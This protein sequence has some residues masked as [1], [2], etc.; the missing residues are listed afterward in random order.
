MGTYWSNDD[1]GICGLLEYL[2]NYPLCNIILSLSNTSF[3]SVLSL[4]PSRRGL[5][6]PGQFIWSFSLPL[7]EWL[8]LTVHV[9]GFHKLSIPWKIVFPGVFGLLGDSGTEQPIKVLQTLNRLLAA[10]RS[11]SSSLNLMGLQLVI[12]GSLG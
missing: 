12:R 4:K 9:Y 3:E 6:I 1:K 8:S 11:G 7:I 2:S 10:K 5:V